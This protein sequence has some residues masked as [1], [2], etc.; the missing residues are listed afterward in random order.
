MLWNGH[1]MT[2]DPSRLAACFALTSNAQGKRFLDV[3][4]PIVSARIANAHLPVKRRYCGSAL[5][6]HSYRVSLCA[7]AFRC[8]G[9][10]LAVTA[11]LQRM[12]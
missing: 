6:T 4:H 5:M 1:R 10:G 3:S 2:F 7:E 9:L 8:A 12:A 11:Q